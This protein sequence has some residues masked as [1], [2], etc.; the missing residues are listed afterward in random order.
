MNHACISVE[1][2]MFFIAKM[3]DSQSFSLISRLSL[4]LSCFIE[5]DNV[6]IKRAVERQK[7]QNISRNDK[8]EDSRKA[9]SS[10]R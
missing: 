6:G 7:N 9:T 10:P 1:F 2:S 4:I 5:Y 8:K 3:N